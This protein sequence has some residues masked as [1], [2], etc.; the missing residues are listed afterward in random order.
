M[1]PLCAPCPTCAPGTVSARSTSMRPLRGSSCIDFGS[2]TSPR[3]TS[4]VFKVSAAVTTETF[5]LFS[6]TLNVK[7]K[8]IC[9]PT[10]TTIVRT[11]LANPGALA[12]IV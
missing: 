9:W 10:S 12:S 4:C 1:S 11:I 2:T 8:V 5:S 6:L 7:S 3:L